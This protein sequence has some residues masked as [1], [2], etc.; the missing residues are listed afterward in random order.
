MKQLLLALFLVFAAPAFADGGDQR[1][2]VDLDEVVEAGRV[3][4]VNG[5]TSAGQPD[6]AELDVFADSGYAVVID[7]RG[8]DEDRGMEDFPGVVEAKAMTYVAFP[9]ASPG[10]IPL[11][12]AA[13]LDELL[14]R[15]DGPALLHCGSG[16]RVGA[17]LALRQSLKGADDESAIAYGRDA[18]MTRLEPAVRKVL[19][20]D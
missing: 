2:L 20:K 7:M 13:A 1:I 14:A 15:I 5:I 11:E 19:E 3:T 12:K 8:P 9:I 16:N 17:I 18:G 10:D 4:P 6:A